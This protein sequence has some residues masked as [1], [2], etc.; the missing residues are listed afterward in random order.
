MN[1]S[2]DIYTSIHK[3]TV[4]LFDIQRASF[5]DGPGIRTTV[6]FKGCNLKCAWCHNPESQSQKTEMMFYKNRCTGCGKCREKCPNNLEKCNFCGKCVLYCPHDARE[7]C[8]REYTVDEVMREI[9][10][11]KAF[12]ENSGGGVTFSGGE[13]MLQIDFLEEILKKCKEEG[14]HTAVDTAGH[15]PPEYFERIIPYTDLFLY[16]V[17]I[18]DTEKHKKY[19]GVGNE[20]ILSNLKKLLD[21]GCRVIVR[22]PVIV[23]VNDSEEE[24]EAIK[25]IAEKAEKIELLPYHAMGEHKYSALGKNEP[26]FSPPTEEKMLDLRNIL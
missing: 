9:V 15:L 24:I 17:K 1:L 23:G 22:T 25:K 10:K 21:R 8:G 18:S 16:D 4:L 11:D 19:V 3:D 2:K 5:V 20:L 14:I 6:F 26:K 7:I 12:Y 13:C